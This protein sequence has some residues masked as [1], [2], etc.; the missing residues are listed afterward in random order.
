M[1]IKSTILEH[2]SCL[3]CRWKHKFRQ[4]KSWQFLRSCQ[5]LLPEQTSQRP[6]QQRTGQKTWR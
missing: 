5:S 6:V 4:C 2:S 1:D 3:F